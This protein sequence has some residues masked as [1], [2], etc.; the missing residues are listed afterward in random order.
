MLPLAFKPFA[1]PFF[2]LFGSAGKTLIMS[3]SCDCINNSTTPAV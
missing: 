2:Q 3:D 1:V